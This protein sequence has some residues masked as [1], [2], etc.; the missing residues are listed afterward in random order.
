[1]V[2]DMNQI[3]QSIFKNL[4]FESRRKGKYL[5]KYADHFLILA[6]EEVA[7]TGWI[8]FSRLTFLSFENSFDNVP[9][10]STYFADYQ[11]KNL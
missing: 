9:Q 7:K 5:S 11:E 1:M 4:L 8:N 6:I 2:N 10:T 3:D